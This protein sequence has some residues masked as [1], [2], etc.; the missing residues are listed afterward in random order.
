MASAERSRGSIADRRLE[1]MSANVW[2]RR[3]Y[4]APTHND[5][6]RVLIDRVWPRGVSREA[7]RIEAWARPV[8]PSDELRKWFDHRAERWDEFRRRYRAELASGEAR[9]QLDELVALTRRRR[10]TLV[11]GASDE[12]HNNAVALREVIEERLTP[13]GR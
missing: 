13:K 4:D 11:Y 6:C 5:G 1:P 12:L 3:A 2:I 7:L 10:V 8:A 9:H